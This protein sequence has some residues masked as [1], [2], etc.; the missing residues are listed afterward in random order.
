[1]CKIETIAERIYASIAVKGLTKII[2]SY[3]SLSS[4]LAKIKPNDG[5]SNSEDKFDVN[6][7]K[8]QISNFINARFE[9]NNWFKKTQD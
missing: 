2:I 5:I 4:R 8:D 9:W 3:I 6:L 7:F 1:M